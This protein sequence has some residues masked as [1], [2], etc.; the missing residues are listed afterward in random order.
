M[1]DGRTVILKCRAYLA[2]EGRGQKNQ[3]RNIPLALQGGDNRTVTAA[4]QGLPMSPDKWPAGAYEAT[5]IARIGSDK[6]LEV[7]GLKFTLAQTNL[8]IIARPDAI[9]ELP[10]D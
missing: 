6:T 1:P 7:P 10:L 3:S 5:L 4:F 2:E 8:N 9:L